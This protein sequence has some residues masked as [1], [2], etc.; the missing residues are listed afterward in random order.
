MEKSQIKSLLISPMVILLGLAMALAGSHQGASWAGIPV[1]A[2]L[3]G[4]IFVLQ[5]LAFLPA[6]L[7]Q[8]EKFFDLFG[9]LTYLAVVLL[10]LFSRDQMDLRSTILALLVAVWAVRLGA[11]LFTRIRRAGKD[12]R[13]DQLKPSFIRFCNVW[14][15]QGLWITF[16]LAAALAAIS[17]TVHKKPGLLDLFGLML[18]L[19]GFVIEVVADWQKSRFNKIIENRGRYI[20]SGLWSRSRHPNYFGEIVLWIGLAVL[21]APVLRGWQWLTLISPV[22]VF[23]LLT[24]ISGIP[25]LEKKAEAKWGG[26]KD[27]Q[28]YKKNTPALFPRLFAVNRRHD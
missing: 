9:S 27:F 20:H 8:T 28:E 15:M 6:F 4:L 21:A 10:A 1:F 25:L 13:F 22:F 14:T 7:F 2:L 3:V 12:E 17:G 16:T 18:W 26:Q 23:I 5:W 11:F 24:R 19:G